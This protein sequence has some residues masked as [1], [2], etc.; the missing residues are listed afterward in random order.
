MQPAD[1]QL[2]AAS[3]VDRP[4]RPI[5][6]PWVAWQVVDEGPGRL[7][8]DDAARSPIALTAIVGARPNFVKMAPIL[9]EAGRRSAFQCRLVH[10]GQHY[11]PQ[12]SAARPSSMNW[13]CRNLM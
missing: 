7:R 11:S 4:I 5:A 6:D 8:G 2:P 10:T 9:A 13:G 3:T 1:S 12:M